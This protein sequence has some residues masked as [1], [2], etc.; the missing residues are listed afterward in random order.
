M[1]V[2]KTAILAGDFTHASA[3]RLWSKIDRRSADACWPWTC[4]LSHGYGAL[5][6]G[7]GRKVPAAGAVFALING[8]VPA[9]KL[10]RHS[11]DNPPCCNPAHLLL[12]DDKDNAD[13]RTARGR[14]EPNRARGDRSGSRLHPET[15]P[16]GERAA[17]AKLTEADVREIRRRSE[18]GEGLR[19]LGRA[20]GVSGNAIRDVCLGKSWAHVRLAKA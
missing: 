17:K 19:A 6:I 5:R 13:D 12:G 4:G 20:F 9:G 2:R 15:R 3:R 18:A 14:D 7:H 10:V 8:S 11:C 16:R 1:G